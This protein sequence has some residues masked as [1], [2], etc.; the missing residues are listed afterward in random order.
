MLAAI[1]PKLF[2]SMAYPD[3]MMGESQLQEK[4]AYGGKDKKLIL[5]QTM[6]YE[7]LFLIDGIFISRSMDKYYSK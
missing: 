6:C 3:L 1:E 5:M 2:V 7:I 4:D